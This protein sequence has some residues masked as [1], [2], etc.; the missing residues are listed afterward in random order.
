[1]KNAN[2]NSKLKVNS[3]ESKEPKEIKYESLSLDSEEN[4]K[5]M[6]GHGVYTV[7]QLQQE[8]DS[9]SEIGKKL[10]TVEEKLKDY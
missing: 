9:N 2:P 4:T 8:I 6:A 10:K 1:M 5:I 7:K 3:G